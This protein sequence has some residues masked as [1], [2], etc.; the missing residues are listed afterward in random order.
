MHNFPDF[1]HDFPGE[2]IELAP[3]KAP[4]WMHRLI[5]RIQSGKMR[6]PLT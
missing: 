2:N 3:D 6:D 5:E 4:V 1:P